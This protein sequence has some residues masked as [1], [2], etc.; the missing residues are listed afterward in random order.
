M[1]VN[2]AEHQ[3]SLLATMG[4]DLWVPRV[5]V[6]IRHFQTALYRDSAFAIELSQ[7]E[8]LVP[9]PIDFF[10]QDHLKQKHLQQ[11]QQVVHP[12][13]DLQILNLQAPNLQSLNIQTSNLAIENLTPLENNTVKPEQLQQNIAD[14]ALLRNSKNHPQK[15]EKTSNSIQPQTPLS[16]EPAIQIEAFEIQAFCLENC[17][18]LVD[19]T[20]LTAEQTTL[21]LNIQ[22][23]TSGQF[24]ELK[25]PFPMMQYQDGKGASM[26]VQGFTDALKQER[27]VLSL[28]QLAHMN[29]SEI[30]QL[31]SLQEMLD[32]PILKRRLWQFMQNLLN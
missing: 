8:G 11:D 15:A 31:A 19:C 18:I 6:Q 10:S 1:S 26:Y 20:H 9:A 17:V 23:A 21:W 29:H 32:Q 14:V 27:K 30:V 24:Y 13:S 5:D 4:I 25:W 12:P 22:R 16:T 2:L 28:G 7:T 3:R